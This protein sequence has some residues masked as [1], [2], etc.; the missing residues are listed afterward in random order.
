MAPGRPLTRKLRIITARKP[1]RQN[2]VKKHQFAP[3]QNKNNTINRRN[4]SYRI[5]SIGSR[6][7]AFWAGYQ[8]KKIPVTVQTANDSTTE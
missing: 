5:A 6:R 3:T 8:P 2:D 1:D 4:Y 7:A